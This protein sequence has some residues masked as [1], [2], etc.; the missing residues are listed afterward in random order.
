MTVAPRT[1]RAADFG[2]QVECSRPEGFRKGV[3]SRSSPVQEIAMSPR[4]VA[5]LL[6]ACT[7]PALLTACASQ[8][9]SASVQAAPA[10]MVAAPAA[11]KHPNRFEMTRNG[12]RMSADDFDAWMKARGIR[13][14]EGKPQD[15]RKKK[16]AG[17]PAK[18]KPGVSSQRG[19]A[20][21]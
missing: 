9:K 4:R 5:A 1:R 10:P 3:E 13:I 15:D 14:A 7:L 8:P 12:K 16:P 19:T 18:P 21:R 2:V 6:C 11:G 20:Q 17:K